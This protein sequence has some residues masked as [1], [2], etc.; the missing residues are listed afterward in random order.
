VSQG[1]QSLPDGR[2]DLLKELAPADSAGLFG[3]HDIFL[4]PDGKDLAY[5]VSRMLSE[6]YAVEGLK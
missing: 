2:K 3:F 1:K 6:L 4:T 5:S